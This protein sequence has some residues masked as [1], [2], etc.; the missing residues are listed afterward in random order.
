MH[1]AGRGAAA[2]CW[3]STAAHTLASSC[4]GD[5]PHSDCSHWHYAHPSSSSSSSSSF[6]PFSAFTARST[7]A[8][9]GA[10]GMDTSLWECPDGSAGQPQSPARSSATRRQ[11]SSRW[12]Q[13]RPSAHGEWYTNTV[14]VPPFIPKRSFY[15]DRLGTKHRESSTQKSRGFPRC[16]DGRA[17]DHWSGRKNGLCRA[18]FDSKDRTFAKTGSG[19]T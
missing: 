8:S 12:R 1:C 14:S 7:R 10:E 16:A 17:L 6:R 13:W 11:S 2:T 5:T 3:R 19:Q 4:A 18:P 15:Q 9:S